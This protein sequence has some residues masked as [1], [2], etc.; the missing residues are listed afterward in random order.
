MSDYLLGVDYG[1]GGTKACI[2]NLSGEVLGYAYREYPIRRG[3][4]TIRIATGQHSAK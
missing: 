1:T 4:S 3:P 2:I